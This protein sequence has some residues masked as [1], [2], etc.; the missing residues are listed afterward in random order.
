MSHADGTNLTRQDQKQLSAA[1][2]GSNPNAKPDEAG[3]QPKAAAGAS[4]AA[5]SDGPAFRVP[6]LTAVGGVIMTEWAYGRAGPQPVS[7]K[8]ASL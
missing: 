7:P 1:A 3:A 5:P 4:G 6:P 2:E 8:T